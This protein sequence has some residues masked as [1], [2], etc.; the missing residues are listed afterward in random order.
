MFNTLSSQDIAEN[1]LTI[2]EPTTE[3]VHQSTNTESNDPY[4][5]SINIYL[6]FTLEEEDQMFREVA[7]DIDFFEDDCDPAGGYGL[8]SH[9]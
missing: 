6:P 3:R 1:R 2:F 4:D 5:F 9:V 8:N 7:D